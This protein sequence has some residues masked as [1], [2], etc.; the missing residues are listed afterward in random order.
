VRA[1]QIEMRLYWDYTG[2]ALNDGSYKTT[3][4]LNKMSI[5]YYEFTENRRLSRKQY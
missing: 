2:N 5:D 1:D 3:P 4:V